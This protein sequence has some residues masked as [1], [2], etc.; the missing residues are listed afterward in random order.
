M[1]EPSL[2]NENDSREHRR[3]SS[4]HSDAQ[5]VGRSRQPE[6]NHG[7]TGIYLKTVIFSV[8]QTVKTPNS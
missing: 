7:F 5:A 6:S 3:R 1:V 2:T 8:Q 4:S